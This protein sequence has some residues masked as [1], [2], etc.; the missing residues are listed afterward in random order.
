M[1]RHE[2]EMVTVLRRGRHLGRRWAIRISNQTLSIRRS[3]VPDSDEVY[4]EDKFGHR[5]G[6]SGYNEPGTPTL[7]FEIV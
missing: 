7:C 6:H 4:L 2:R 3:R 5:Y 1:S